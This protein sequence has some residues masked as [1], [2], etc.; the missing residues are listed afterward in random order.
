MTTDLKTPVPPPSDIDNDGGD[1]AEE[2]FYLDG[3]GET[4]LTPKLM[5]LTKEVNRD[6][7][8]NAAILKLAPVAS[9]TVGGTASRKHFAV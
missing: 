4:A 8:E 1:D 7:C 2:S 6:S 9:F 3:F 5:E